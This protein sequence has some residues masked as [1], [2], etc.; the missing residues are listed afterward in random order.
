MLNLAPLKVVD[1]LPDVFNTLK[2]GSWVAVGVSGD[3]SIKAC[4]LGE[5]DDIIA[6]KD[7]ESKAA[8]VAVITN[9]RPYSD[10]VGLVWKVD[11]RR[12]K[13]PF[14]IGMLA[15]GVA[16]LIGATCFE[17]CGH[18]R[19][20]VVHEKRL[21]LIA[22]LQGGGYSR[23]RIAEY[24]QRCYGAILCAER[25]W[26]NLYETNAEF[27]ADLDSLLKTLDIKLCKF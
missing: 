9:I 20:R 7:S 15:S 27:R 17:M 24:L 16:K 14:H 11:V 8:E 2:E 12:V 25:A 6:I 1:V 10:I 21:L 26:H 4:P 22:A 19:K 5:L 13:Q 23:T 3:C 18:S